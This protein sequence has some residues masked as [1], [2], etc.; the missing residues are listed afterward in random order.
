MLSLKSFTHECK[1]MHY[2]NHEIPTD[3]S[4]RDNTKYLF[5]TKSV[6]CNES[7]VFQEFLLVR[8]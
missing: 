5:N 8:F 4:L 2:F 6:K 1:Y 3:L 7:E